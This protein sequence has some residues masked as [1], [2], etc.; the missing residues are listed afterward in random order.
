MNQTAPA[1]P[2]PLCG[3]HSA[4]Y[5]RDRRSYLQCQTCAL[6][7]VP[8]PW[9]LDPGQEHAEYEL[10]Q[11]DPE[12]PGYRQF[13]S[14]LATPLLDRLPPHSHG[15]DF[16]C[17]PGPALAAMLEERGHSVALYDLFYHPDASTLESRYDFIT[18]TEVIEHLA[19]PRKELER[20]WRLVKPGGWLGIMT[21]RVRDRDAFAHW[22]YKNDPTHI[23]F[24]SEATFKWLAEALDAELTI[25]QPD[26]VLLRKPAS[27]DRR[28]H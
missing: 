23:A 17:G 10:H 13:L 18:A 2:C 1:S 5:F 19:H 12:D 4:E 21:K 22:H 3:A 26:V 7:H 15:L 16:G 9:H 24:F 28:F 27:A 11:N 6:V 20:L 14:R 25:L 8:P